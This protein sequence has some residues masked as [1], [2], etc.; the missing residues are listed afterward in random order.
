MENVLVIGLTNRIDLIDPALL[1]PGRF[2]T[3]IEVQLPGRIERQDILALLLR[4]L[5][6]GQFAPRAE[7]Q[8]WVSRLA[9]AT[10]GFSGADLAGLVRAAVAHAI[11][12][13]LST[14]SPPSELRVQ[15]QDF[16][17]AL[18]ERRRQR[19]AVSWRGRLARRVRTASRPFA[20]AFATTKDGQERGQTRRSRSLAEAMEDDEHASQEVRRAP[21]K[22]NASA[23]THS[24][25]SSPD[26]SSVQFK[27]DPFC[28]I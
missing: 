12:Q 11:N 8:H 25:V 2:D 10:D 22:D 21:Q 5:V 20:F 26:S 18:K 1:R 19:A 28:N 15:W 27:E 7:A 4:R 14:D 3:H 9:R 6:T 16:S 17:L 13:Y 23:T 24:P